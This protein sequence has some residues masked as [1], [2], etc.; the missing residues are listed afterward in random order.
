[1]GSYK[2][3]TRFR[4]PDQPCQQGSRGSY[5]SALRW[6]QLSQSLMTGSCFQQCCIAAPEHLTVSAEHMA[7][8]LLHLHQ[9][10]LCLVVN[11]QDANHCLRLAPAALWLVLNFSHGMQFPMPCCCF[12]LAAECYPATP[13]PASA[14]ERESCH[15]DVDVF[16]SWKNRII[17][18][19]YLH[20]ES[21]KLTMTFFILLYCQ[22]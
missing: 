22:L 2:F 16:V 8:P 12:A 6:N 1:M 19:L 3:T 14:A 18:D 10:C 7:H 20:L 17:S 5:M 9:W 13:L 4:P 15:L 11:C 21:L